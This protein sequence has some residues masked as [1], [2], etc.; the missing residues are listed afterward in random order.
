MLVQNNLVNLE[1]LIIVHKLGDKEWL[2]MNDMTRVQK[3]GSRVGNPVYDRTNDKPVVE[4]LC[5]TN[6]D[7][8]DAASPSE[9]KQDYTVQEVK[10]DSGQCDGC[11]GANKVKDS[12]FISD[13]AQENWLLSL[14]PGSMLD[15]CNKQGT[16]FEV[17]LA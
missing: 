16:W 12:L 13:E 8:N 11:E 1:K 3:F 4:E 2:Q 9:T 10:S 7:K 17:R 15:A 14:T 5:S 6:F